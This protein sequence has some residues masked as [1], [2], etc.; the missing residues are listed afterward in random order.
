M[1]DY[2]AYHWFTAAFKKK[3]ELLEISS[4]DAADI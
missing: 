2:Q 1:K 3:I 4:R